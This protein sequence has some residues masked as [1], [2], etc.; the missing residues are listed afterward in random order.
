ME[1]AHKGWRDSNREGDSA[2]GIEHD[3]QKGRDDGEVAR[4]RWKEEKMPKETE[5]S[6]E[7][8]E[9]KGGGRRQGK[10]RGERKVAGR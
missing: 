6:P 7:G 10:R 5:G 9:A 2:R 8:R 3:G 1:H 4:R